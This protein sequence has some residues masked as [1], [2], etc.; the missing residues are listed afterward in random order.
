MPAQ[1]IAKVAAAPTKKATAT[2]A[3]AARLVSVKGGRVTRRPH[4][5][6]SQ[7]QQQQQKRQEEEED[8]DFRF[9]VPS[10]FLLC[11]PS[12]SGKSTFV[13]NLL[14][15]THL[16]FREKRI[17][18]NVIYFYKHW[19]P[20]FK[21]FED[22]KIVKQFINEMPTSDQIMDLARPFKSKGGSMF[23]LDDWQQ[24]V[25]QDTAQLFRGVAHHGHA[26]ICF[27]SQAIFPQNQAF[28]EISRNASYLIV[29]KSLRDTAQI[30]TLARQISPRR[31]KMIMDVF[32]DVTDEK[33]YSY[34]CFRFHQETPSF[35]KLTTNCLPHEFPVVC[36]GDKKE[37][38]RLERRVTER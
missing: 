33:A 34:L 37:F 4:P 19:N 32:A 9:H 15:N 30:G 31:A 27:L 2:T 1:T 22:R 8:I 35:L 23:I 3:A 12:S 10:T 28:R 25:S 24:C 16:M 26:V 36:F 21:L 7:Q 20:I 29:F 6:R 18:Q 5:P 17:A 11:G 38:E 13:L 14:L